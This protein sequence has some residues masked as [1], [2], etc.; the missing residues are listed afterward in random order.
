[1]GFSWGL[2]KQLLRGDVGTKHKETPK[3][4][5]PKP[6]PREGR[7][8]LHL[9]RHAE[10]FNNLN[11][12]G[13]G[14]IVDPTLTRKGFEQCDGLATVL[15]HLQPSLILASPMARTLQTATRCLGTKAKIIADPNLREFGSVPNCTGSPVEKL[16]K[17]FEPKGVNFSKVSSGWEK[18]KEKDGEYKRGRRRR[19]E[20]QKARARKV[21]KEI[22]E[23]ANKRPDKTKHYRAL[24]VSHGEFLHALVGHGFNNAELRSF[25]MSKDD[26]GYYHFE[27][28]Y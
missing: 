14:Q 10:A 22:F 15:Q 21:R 27:E 9:V 12:R 5:P 23:L 3:A 4:A 13:V 17:V 20:E 24:I 16:K 28:V 25:I 1:M 18:N 6:T 19:S 7:I 2:K 26:R 8:I 11:K